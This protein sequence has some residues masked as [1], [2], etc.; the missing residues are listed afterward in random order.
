MDAKVGMADRSAW[1][2]IAVVSDHERLNDA[3]GNFAFIVPGQVR[4]YPLD[5]LD[6]A[7]AWLAET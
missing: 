2:R 4:T 7:K 5:G 6:E 1:D 3:V